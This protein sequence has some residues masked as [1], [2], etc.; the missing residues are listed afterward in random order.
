MYRGISF[1]LIIIF[2]FFTVITSITNVNAQQADDIEISIQEFIEMQLH[3]EIK[4]TIQKGD[5]TVEKFVDGLEWPTTMTFI[6]NDLLVFE[7][8]KGTV[9]HIVNGVLIDKPVLDLSVA[10]AV[11]GGL[12]GITSEGNYVY[13][14]LTESNVDGGEYTGTRILKYFWNG[15]KLVDREVIREVIKSQDGIQHHGGILL[16]RN[17]VPYEIL[18]VT[19]DNFSNT[20]NQNF[21]DSVIDDTSAIFDISKEEYLGV[22]IRN[23]F[24]L[25]ED[26]ITKKIWMTE[27][28]PDEFDEINLVEP[29]FNSG[30]KVVWGPSSEKDR[31]ELKRNT[32]FLYSEP[33]FSWEQTIGVTAISF[34][35]SDKFPDLKNSVLVGDFNNGNLYKFQL[36]NERTGFI[37]E[38][39]NLNDLVLNYDDSN[40]E[41]I[42]GVGFSGITDIKI[43]PE[44]LPYIISIGDGTIYRIIPEENKKMNM[45]FENFEECEIVYKTSTDLSRCDLSNLKLDNI[46]LSGFNLSDV[47]LSNSSLKNSVLSNVNLDGANLSNVDLS[48]SKLMNSV[49]RNADLKNSNLSNTDMRYTLL[50]NSNLNNVIMENTDI[51]WSNLEF[52]Q[53]KNAKINNS[54]LMYTNFESTNFSNTE[55]SKSRLHNSEFL[56]AKFHDSNFTNNYIAYSIFTNADFSGAKIFQVTPY[57]SEIFNGEIIF[58]QDTQSDVCLEKGFSAK[59]LNRII[60]EMDKLESGIFNEIKKLILSLC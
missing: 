4:P 40:N 50:T 31:E 29:K 43:G 6:D 2:S 57:S 1:S 13:L 20:T 12:L 27:N 54:E 11:E 33:E 35:D 22:G 36:N 48:N 60:F 21:F 7:K 17:T 24:G 58:S 5:Y 14:F 39:E 47:D 45:G 10:N 46:N 52:A 49:I 23:S 56:N 55:I 37:F 26:P 18:A 41:I 8:N 28:G 59:I 53:L 51:S 19:G 32:E 15:E 30:W 44:G 9:R 16:S 3:L 25:T 38:N 42:F 34:I